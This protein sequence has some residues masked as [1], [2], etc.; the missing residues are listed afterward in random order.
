MPVLDLNIL[1]TEKVDHLVPTREI[2]SLQT[3]FKMAFK[4]ASG[5]SSIKSIFSNDIPKYPWPNTQ[6]HVAGNEILFSLS[7]VSFIIHL[8]LPKW[9]SRPCKRGGQLADPRSCR[10][11]LFSYNK[12]PFLFSNL[13]FHK[14]VIYDRIFFLKLIS[15][16]WYQI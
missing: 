7:N 11:N 9:D 5:R 2:S 16:F 3:W 8:R 15:S 6:I 1:T 4:M 13:C 10:W 12:L 14:F